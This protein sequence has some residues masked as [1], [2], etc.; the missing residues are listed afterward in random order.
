MNL[1]GAVKG[2]SLYLPKFRI[3]RG[4]IA[5][6]HSTRA[7]GTRTVRWYDEDEFTM[8]F[9]A[10][11]KL[12]E[13]A[14]G[15]DVGCVVFASER[16]PY[17]LK[18]TAPMIAR[19]LPN[20]RDVLAFDIAGSDRVSADG[21]AAGVAFS[22]I[23]GKDALLAGG[24]SIQGGAGSQEEMSG[25]DAGWAMLI[26]EGGGLVLESAHPVSADDFIRWDRDG[27]YV[28]LPD[29]FTVPYQQTPSMLRA[30]RGCSKTRKPKTIVLGSASEQIAK[31]LS[32]RIADDG[33][34]FVSNPVEATGDLG[35]ANLP[36][37]L[38]LALKECGKGDPVAIVSPGDGALCFSG[39]VEDPP[40]VKVIGANAGEFETLKAYGTYR[41]I[42]EYSFDEADASPIAYWR[43]AGKILS[44]TGGKCAECGAIF[45]P[46]SEVCPSCGARGNHEETS[47]ARKGSIFTYTTD[48]ITPSPTGKV[49][50]TVVDLDGGGRI[51]T[52]MTDFLGETVEIGSTVELVIRNVH[53]GGGIKNYGWKS[54]IKSA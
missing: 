11:L 18:S 40:S 35:P 50:H 49:T 4:L 3:E 51:Y 39:V 45:Y 46:P 23:S 28:S 53:S 26:G 43:D 8:A 32:K 41:K 36:F 12:V 6:Q 20:A 34:N 9:E 19:M 47:L 5:E 22:Q 44:L 42:V 54:R 29:G 27:E 16:G 10:A 21:I 14:G 48:H 17:R 30:L 24:S 7:R 2:L 52:H 1:K 38:S 33:V 31:S 15:S 13:A 37:A 25:G